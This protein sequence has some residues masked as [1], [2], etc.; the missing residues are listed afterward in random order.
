MELPSIEPPA[1]RVEHDPDDGVRITTLDVAQ[2]VETLAAIMRERDRSRRADLAEAL[3][4]TLTAWQPRT[5][6]PTAPELAD[7]IDDVH[8]ALDMYNPREKRRDPAFLD[9]DD[10][11]RAIESALRSLVVAR[12]EAIA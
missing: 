8:F 9:D 7:V 3:C 1:P 12:T 11:D 5:G 2:L 6:A 10:L 4:P